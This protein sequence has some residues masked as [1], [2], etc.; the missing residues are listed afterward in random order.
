MPAAPAAGIF[1]HSCIPTSVHPL[2]PV[3]LPRLLPP[4][5]NT[6]FARTSWKSRAFS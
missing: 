3:C 5:K 6:P 4:V 2:S 1:L